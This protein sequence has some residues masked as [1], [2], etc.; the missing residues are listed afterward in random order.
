MKSHEGQLITSELL[1]SKILNTTSTCIFWKD[2]QRRFVGVNQ[3]FLD[4]Y[5]FSSEA[6]LIGKTDE[7]MLWHSDPDPFQS[8]EW[9]V[10]K[11]G[12]STVRVHGKCMARGQE[13]D[14]LASKSPIYEDGKIIGLVGTFEDVTS[15]YQQ[16][17][18]IRK[19][20]QT[21]DHIP[22]GICIGQIRF[23]RIVCISANEYFADMVGG[24]PEE[25]SGKDTADLS[26]W[27]HPDDIPQWENAA[28][29]L[30]SDA[31]VMDGVY[32]FRNR[33]TGEYVWLRMKGCRARLQDDEEFL[34][35][36][37]TDENE[38]TNSEK[39]ESALRKLY[40]ASVDAAELVVWEYDV[41]THTVTFD[42]NGYTARR[43]QEIG[44]PR[45][46]HNI[47]EVLYDI[48]PTEYHAE[49]KRFY[50][51]VF[52]G[53]STSTADIA[54]RPFHDQPQLFL[55]LSYT[56]ILDSDGKPLKAYGTSQD[57]TQ[58][59][60]AEMLYEHELTF[61]NSERQM[62]FIAKGHFDLTAN[63]TLGYYKVNQAALSVKGMACDEVYEK[64]L[65][66]IEYEDDRKRYLDLFNPK[67]MIARFHSGETGC[68]LEYRRS[69]NETPAMWVLMEARTFQNPSTGNIEC[70]I[71]VYDVTEKKIQQQLSCNL[72]SIGY[73]NV[74]LISIPNQKITYYRLADGGT[75]MIHALA[76]DYQT[77]ADELF[78]R[79]VPEKDRTQILAESR[80]DTVLKALAEHESYSFSFTSID[81]DQK[82]HRK[83]VHYSHM[84]LDKSVV[85]LSV[86]DISEQYA[87]EQEQ[88]AMLQEAIRRGDAAN[89][90]KS[91][92][93]S[94]MSH[95]IRTPMNGIIGMTYL[96]KKQQDIRKVYGYLDKID[97]SS[98]F[99]L[100]LV[101]DILDMSKIESGKIELKQE[102]YI[103]DR[104]LDYLGAVIKPLCEEKGQT[105]VVDAQPVTSVAPLMDVLRVNQ[106][107]FNLFSNAVKY[108]PEGGTITFRLR[109]T[110][111]D[112][113]HLLMEADV[114]DT[115][116]GMSEELQKSAFEP[117]TQGE[118]SDTSANRGTGL[119]LPIVKSLIEL[120]GGTVSVT[121][122]LGT[123]SVF[124][125][126]AVF[127]VVPATS[128]AQKTGRMD[129]DD[130]P[131]ALANRHVLLCEDH[132]LNQEIAKTILENWKMIVNTAENGEIGVRDFSESSTG[133]YDVILMDIRMPVM[134][135][136]EATKAIRTLN[137]QDAGKVPILAMTADVFS[138]DVQKC[139][140]AGMNGHIAKPIDPKA[141][142]A[143]LLQTIDSPCGFLI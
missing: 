59:K 44:L 67:K 106:I 18:A 126:K 12:E 91:D 130:M 16:K 5:G 36:T 68:S 125:I 93:L 20:T 79:F 63:K 22:C 19:L 112:G 80:F 114:A 21:L 110:L 48:I 121:S 46:F 40:A 131:D 134:D 139:L 104:F 4:Y 105:L 124:H 100:G 3:A 49:I 102:P 51:D 138:D 137:R 86:Q 57:L 82:P 135:G 54:F 65:P 98:K 32:R 96:A 37:F 69:G 38:L 101:N 13:R 72:H 8:D 70:F 33:K 132:P 62:N 6:E 29:G 39:R 141:L 17:D 61:M 116:I 113:N 7:D 53:K 64:L 27:L 14:I 95:D 120:M 2:D 99:L 111:V 78:A 47:P 89:R 94:R 122:E 140:E 35:C 107:F 45:V 15:D 119:G 31:G 97:T 74:G 118:R 75:W 142:Y 55:H 90:A 92:F 108:T 26:S 88:I 1:L 81:H 50:E 58:E 71:Y 10:L 128:V 24:E 133:Y 83:F 73:E 87:R 25:F 60:T 103:V 43:C 56:V 123:G 41:A 28:K 30:C 23:G 9:R 77:I 42:Q 52:A 84:Y 34:Y 85:F 136:I 115:G 76:M 129:I 143:A 117:F 127:D 66:L 11:K 109:E